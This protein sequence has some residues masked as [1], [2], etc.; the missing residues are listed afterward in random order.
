MLTIDIYIAS[1]SLKKFTDDFQSFTTMWLVI[2]CPPKFLMSITNSDV[3]ASDAAVG[4]ILLICCIPLKQ[5]LEIASKLHW[6]KS[7]LIKC[8]CLLSLIK[9][10]LSFTSAQPPSSLSST[11]QRR[12]P[13]FFFRVKK[14]DRYLYCLNPFGFKLCLIQNKPGLEHVRYSL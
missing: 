13:T 14:R 3:H 4:Y 8:G 10:A 1:T 9:T 5:I 12:L 2:N 6:A 7:S 11:S